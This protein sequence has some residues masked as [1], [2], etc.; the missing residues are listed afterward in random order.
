[1]YDL[2]ESLKN[3]EIKCFMTSSLILIRT[4]V[5][6]CTL[7]ENQFAFSFNLLRIADNQSSMMKF[8]SSVKTDESDNF[9]NVIVKTITSSSM[10]NKNV[11]E[12]KICV[13]RSLS[14]SFTFNSRMINL[15]SFNL[16]MQ[17]LYSVINS[18]N[19]TI[20]LLYSFMTKVLSSQMFI[21]ALIKAFSFFFS[22]YLN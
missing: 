9:L 16:S 22:Q 2:I 1:M 7:I 17:L 15:A 14:R 12:L 19:F 3:R 5:F 10:I 4:Y 21:H 11:F 18:S 6:S 20:F 8:L 13:E